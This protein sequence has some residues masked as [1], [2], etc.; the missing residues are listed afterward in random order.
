MGAAVAECTCPELVSENVSGEPG[1]YPLC[2]RKLMA[3]DQA[4][5]AAL[6]PFLHV[7]QQTHCQGHCDPRPEA[8]PSPCPCYRVGQGAC[9]LLGLQRA[10]C[11]LAGLHTS[12]K[13]EPCMSKQRDNLASAQEGCVMC[14]APY[15]F[16]G[17][18]HNMAY[19][20]VKYRAG[21]SS[22]KFKRG[23]L[24]RATSCTHLHRSSQ[25]YSQT[26]NS[27]AYWTTPWTRPRIE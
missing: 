14:S 18:Q 10:S 25:V 2:P 13:C 24:C 7:K 4:H 12:S 3:S 5:L 17:M 8:L 19:K 15:K 21:K 11:R 20:T 9:A 23:R 16:S 27:R 26:Q 22:A 1:H 6:T